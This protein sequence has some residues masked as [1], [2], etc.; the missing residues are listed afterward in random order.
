MQKR[1]LVWLPAILWMLVI[2]CFSNIPDLHLASDAWLPAKWR[3]FIAQHVLQFGTSGF[4]S[5]QISLYPDFVLHK[6]GHIVFFGVLGLFFCFALRGIGK[7]TLLVGLFAAV[8]EGHQY[9]VVGRSA[10]LGDIV[11]DTLAGLLFIGLWAVGYG[12]WAKR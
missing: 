10:R 7:A 4:F 6:L 12:I 8:D 5:Y 1:L 11:I 3:Q 9:F 2:S